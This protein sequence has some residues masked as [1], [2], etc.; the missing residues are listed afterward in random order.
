MATH[1]V[2][3][4]FDFS[5]LSA[6][7]K[8]ELSR[9]LEEEARAESQKEF[10]STINFLA[11]KLQKMGRTKTD[12][13]QS[14]VMLMDDNERRHYVRSL[15]GSRPAESGAASR[16]APGKRKDSDYLD[17]DGESRAV[18]GKTYQLPENP[19]VRFTRGPVGAINKQFLAAIKSGRKWREMEVK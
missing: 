9:R 10:D 3:P 18:V 15:R 12:A 16:P 2:T 13:V 1:V 8:R 6:S 4:D 5:K 19:E 7:E 11:E 14:L 17:W